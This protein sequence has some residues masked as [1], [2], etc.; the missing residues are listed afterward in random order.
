MGLSDD[1]EVTNK[2]MQDKNF[3][4]INKLQ[5]VNFIANGIEI[6]GNTVWDYTAGWVTGSTGL[7]CKDYYNKTIDA[8][9]A[10]VEKNFPGAKV[11]G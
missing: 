11:S 3:Y 5:Q 8:V 9:K 6:A 10:S 4:P 7:T 1:L 2:S